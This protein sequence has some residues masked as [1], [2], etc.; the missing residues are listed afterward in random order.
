MALS[1]PHRG[2]DLLEVKADY[3]AE[4]EAGH[5]AGLVIPVLLVMF[6]IPQSP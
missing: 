6:T 3:V 5:L 1:S 4:K 2:E